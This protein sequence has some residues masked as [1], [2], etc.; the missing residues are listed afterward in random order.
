VVNRISC[1]VFLVLPEERRERQAGASGLRIKGETEQRPLGQEPGSHWAACQ[2]EAVAQETG[3]AWV[4][5][6]GKGPV[7]KGVQAG[8]H[9][10]DVLDPSWPARSEPGRLGRFDCFHSSHPISIGSSNIYLL[11]TTSL[12]SRG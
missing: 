9:L 12:I 4:V 3:W 11:L 8:G 1:Q 5:L 7:E 2:Q 10:G 6:W